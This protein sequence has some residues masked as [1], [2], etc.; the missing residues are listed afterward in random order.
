[1][2]LGSEIYFTY[3]EL[4]N[5][6]GRITSTGIDPKT[7]AY[8][9]A[10]TWD[11]SCTLTGT[12]GTVACQRSA[13]KPLI[14]MS[15]DAVSSAA[16][17]RQLLVNDAALGVVPFRLS[18]FGPS[19]GVQE[20]ALLSYL[21]GNRSRESAADLRVRSS[22]LG[23][24]INATPVAVGPPN[25]NYDHVLT[26][27]L[28]GTDLS[29]QAHSY[30]Q[31]KADNLRRPG[32]LYGGAN[33]GFVHGFRTGIAVGDT[34]ESTLDAPNDG[35]E[36]LGYMPRPV[37]TNLKANR[38]SIYVTLD[39][40]NTHYAHH[41]YV[42]APAVAGDVYY[43]G[44]W[45]TLLATGLGPGGPVDPAAPNAGQWIVTRETETAYGSVSV[46]DVTHPQS[47]Q[48]NQA[49]ILFKEWSIQDPPVCYDES[50]NNSV[51]AAMP[52]MGGIY[53]APIIQRLH[54]GDFGLIFGNGLYSK[55]GNAGI[56]VVRIDAITGGTTLQYLHGGPSTVANQKNGI[57]SV[58]PSDLDGDGVVDYVYA[59]DVQG[60]VWRFDLSADQPLRWGHAVKIFATPNNQPITS[61]LVVTS[62]NAAGAAHQM[63]TFGTGRVWPLEAP[64]GPLYVRGA[65]SL[66]GIWDWNLRDWNSR[67]PTQYAALPSLPGGSAL[68]VQTIGP[69]QVINGGNYRTSTDNAVCWI[70]ASGV[71]GC[72]AYNQYGWKLALPAAGVQTNE[73][74]VSNPVVYNGHYVVNT[75]IPILN[76][77]YIMSLTLANGGPAVV[78]FFAEAG[79]AP[80]ISGVNVRGMGTP[81][82]LTR[83][84]GRVTHMYFKDSNQTA[85][86]IGIGAPHH[87]PLIKRLTWR[88]LR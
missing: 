73:Q 87:D 69:T 71:P 9:A 17:A 24:S 40:A 82:F 15:A 47:F 19:L 61:S 1:M 68:L 62:V 29:F 66:Y 22:V 25:Q 60:N 12:A 8:A 27:A 83:D 52:N 30:L 70:G 18:S 77:G 5:C 76:D 21:R 10:N 16:N 41:F 85:R 45:H 54:N 34:T 48:E 67:S 13:V 38:D 53:G 20:Q 6:W 28:Y 43:A 51:Q 55:N 11:A 63:V 75:I 33:D 2:A 46:L 7:G 78:G 31:F 80:N 57:V 64:D 84:S 56:F 37:W 86:M 44:E 58:T 79:Q 81:I 50:Q 74:V 49:S 14:A 59:G 26:D 32:V 4:D 39:Y 23:D 88:Q 42:D 3:A 72:G 36:V 35:A 65:Q